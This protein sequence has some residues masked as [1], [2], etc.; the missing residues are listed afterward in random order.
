MDRTEW[1][2]QMRIKTEAL[3]DYGAPL[4]W[5]KWGINDSDN[6]AHREY[7]QIFLGRVAQM[8]DIL[9]AA[10]GAGRYDGILCEAG[11]NV[12]GIDQSAGV[13]ARARQH[14]PQ[15]RFPRLRYE[16]IGLQEMDFHAAYDGIICIDAMEHVCPEDYPVIMRAF[17][18][19]LKPDGLLYFTAETH[20]TAL[21]DG[22]D[23]EEAY[24]NAR[25]QGLPVVPGEVVDEFDSAFSKAMSQLE[26]PG[27]I[28]HNAVYRYY[29]AL[30]QVQAWVEQAGLI[31]VEEGYGNALYH[32]IARRG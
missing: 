17:C 1:L 4:Y 3:Y 27:E 13:L 20:E 18:E 2:K 19:G 14:F 6:E 29:P 5:V 22:E 24:R 12:L 8:G 32:I 31:I 10:C 9:S 21:E 7:L 11:H 28:E 30:D 16:K 26:V 25:A 23:L 15:E